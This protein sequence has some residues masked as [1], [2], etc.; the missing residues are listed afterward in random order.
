MKQST[1]AV[2]LFLVIVFVTQTVSAQP[3]QKLTREIFKELIEI[4]TTHSVGNTTKAAEAMAATAKS[5]RIYRQR[6]FHRRTNRE[7]RKSGRYASRKWKK[8]TD[9]VVSAS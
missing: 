3:D 5:C 4:N 6:Y 8:K 7:K 1:I 2:G 9:F